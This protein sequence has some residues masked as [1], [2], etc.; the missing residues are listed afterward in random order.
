MK[1][2]RLFGISLTVLLITAG[3]TG[4]GAEVRNVASVEVGM[5]ISCQLRTLIRT[6]L[7][8]CMAPSTTAM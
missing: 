4:I 7:T 3:V 6:V 2:K 8:A 1:R 5:P